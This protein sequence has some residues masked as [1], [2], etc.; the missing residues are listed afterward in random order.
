MWEKFESNVPV[1][2]TGRR[3]KIESIVQLVCIIIALVLMITLVGVYFHFCLNFWQVNDQLFY[4]FSFTSWTTGGVQWHWL[5]ISFFLAFQCLDWEPSSFLLSS[6]VKQKMSI[7]VAKK[8]WKMQQKM[9]W[10]M[11]KV[12][13]WRNSFIIKLHSTANLNFSVTLCLPFK[14]LVFSVCQ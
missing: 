11:V 2:Q 3:I 12:A 1:W 13:Q 5:K 14:E 7:F 6:S 10:K 8:M 9:Q 4:I